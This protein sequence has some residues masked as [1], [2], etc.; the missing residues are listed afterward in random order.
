[1]RDV[2]RAGWYGKDPHRRQRWLCKPEND[3]PHRFTPTLTRQ[4]HAHAA[5]HGYCLECS[6]RVEKWEGQAGARYYRFAAREVGEA[7]AY[8]AGG[9]TYRA[10]AFRARQHA[11]RMPDSEYT[12]VERRRRDR[13][14]DGQMVANWVDV[15]ADPLCDGLLPEQWPEILVVDSAGMRVRHGPRQGQAFHIF[16]AVGRTPTPGGLRGALTVVRLQASPVKDAA[17]YES[18]CRS[19]R[20]RPR[21][22]ITDM[23][24][25]L[26]LGVG[27]AFVDANGELPDMRIGEWH[28][29]RSLR[30]RLPDS[31]A[32]DHTNVV[33]QRLGPAFSEPARWHA[34]IAAVQAE[35]AAG[36]HGPLTGLLRWIDE[37]GELVERQSATRDPAL[38]H[39]TSPVEATL[40]EIT[41]RL[42]DRAGN[43]T[44]LARMNKLLALMTLDLHGQADG[45]VWADRVSERTYHLGG[46]APGQRPH[47][48]TRGDTSLTA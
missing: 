47:D 24:H 46:H 43:F 28:L 2:V 1:M 39:S 11:E 14:R 37:H 38:P 4:Y 32:A 33:M 3:R 34:F 41:G 13:A 20:G 44:N 12:G 19:L 21:V 40:R 18:F 6:T 48:D 16:A 8:V 25:G 17:A 31:L 10:A 36:T 7:L 23:D 29:G 27:R 45:R 35:H 26:R 5:P 22:V 15:F 42:R 9:A 30:N